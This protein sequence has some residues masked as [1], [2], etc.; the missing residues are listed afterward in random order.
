V[1]LKPSHQHNKPMQHRPKRQRVQHTA[2]HTAQHTTQHKDTHQF[3]GVR[4]V[5]SA[6][7]IRRICMMG[8]AA[9]VT[10]TSQMKKL[11]R[12]HENTP[13]VQVSIHLAPCTMH[14]APC[15]MH[16]A[17]YTMHHASCTLHHA[18]TLHPLCTPQVSMHHAPC[19]MHHAL[20]LHSLYTHSTLTL[21]SA[22]QHA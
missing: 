5:C 6:P 10:A 1:A 11:V 9:G 19:T 17:P 20:T 12:L 16:H 15:T 8:T 21:H 13:G 22:G 14:H 3:N 7:K 18:L 4:R 2:Q